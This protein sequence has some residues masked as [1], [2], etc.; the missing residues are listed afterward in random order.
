MR[1]MATHKINLKIEAEK[2]LGY[3]SDVFGRR[4]SQTIAFIFERLNIINLVR[5]ATLGDGY[6]MA[7]GCKMRTFI[8]IRTLAKYFGKTIE[9]FVEEFIAAQT[10]QTLMGR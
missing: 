5:I 10:P 3:V 1:K 2:G 6:D 4:K 8:K 9:E 7:V